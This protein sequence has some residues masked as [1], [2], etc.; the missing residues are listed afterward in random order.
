MHI[1]NN[2]PKL[3]TNDRV[4]IEWE[5]LYHYDRHV[6]DYM[7][8]MGY[9]DETLFTV[10]EVDYESGLVW[11][12]EIPNYAIGLNNIIAKNKV[13]DAWFRLAYAYLPHMQLQTV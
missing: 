5:S 6:Q 2:L 9:Q 10:A 8:K 3:E 4:I 12:N 7:N 13:D 1:L 11:V